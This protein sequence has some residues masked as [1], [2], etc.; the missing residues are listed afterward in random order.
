M[1]RY[2]GATAVSIVSQAM[3][4]ADDLISFD[5]SH[6]ERNASVIADVSRSGKRTVRK[7]I[8]DY[9]FI[10]ESRGVRFTCNFVGKCDRIPERGQGSPIRFGKGTLTWKRRLF[11]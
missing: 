10:H 3:I 8:H 1:S 2:T 11:R 9:T 4:S 6:A 5:V 7:S